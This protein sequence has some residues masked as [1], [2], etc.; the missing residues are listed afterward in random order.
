MQSLGRGIS[1][2]TVMDADNVRFRML[3]RACYRLSARP[4]CIG[5]HGLADFI[6]DG[7]HRIEPGVF[8]TL[9]RGRQSGATGRILD[10]PQ[11][12]DTTSKRLSR[13]V[14]SF[15]AGRVGYSRR[16]VYETLGGYVAI[17]SEGDWDLLIRATRLGPC[18][19]F[20]DV[21]HHVS[22]AREQ[23]GARREIPLL[24]HLTLMRAFQAPEN[25]RYHVRVLRSCWRAR[26]MDAMQ[27]RWA[28]LTSPTEW[29]SMVRHACGV[30][31]A[32]GRYVRGRPGRPL[33]AW[34]RLAR[35]V[36]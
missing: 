33:R 1:A 20:D 32:G 11:G 27:Q 15:S 16:V 13:E 22:T 30:I 18:T 28:A 9:G 36:P 3:S 25:S 2:V 12:G 21:S 34:W 31:L 5:A 4:D 24:T 6:D 17:P 19:F 7:G 8:A 23:L 14:L 29:R 35:R 10:W 26:Q